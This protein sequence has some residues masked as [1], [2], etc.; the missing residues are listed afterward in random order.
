M[1]NIQ[2]KCEYS[3]SVERDNY[4]IINCKSCGYWHVYPIPSEEEL[5]TYYENKYYKSLINTEN[6]S[7]TDKKNDHDGFYT[8]Y[9]EDKLRH[10]NNIL[11]KEMPRTIIDIG[12][13]YGD[14]LSFMNKND[15]SVQGIEP[16]KEAYDFSKNEDLNI[17]C[18][19]F[20]EILDL[21][22]KKSSVVTLNNV[23]EHLREP[24]RVLLEI[25]EHLL[26]PDG[27]LSI[28]IPNDFSFFQNLQMKTTLKD[29]L[30]KQYYWVCPLDHL[31]YWS[32]ETIQ[33]FLIRL[34]FE[35]KYITST[36]PIDMFPLMGDDYVTNPEIGR[37]THLKEVRFE[38]ILQTTENWDF[39]DVFYYNLAKLGIGREILVYARP[40]G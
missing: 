23:L 22:F 12:A 19:H 15:W 28:A 24:E 17:R 36:F 1:I 25:K 27:I 20:E 37:N 29:N 8:I 16:S 7:M 32:H 4:T 31:N 6:R 9:Y 18:G 2:S 10:I 5:N 39:K 21:G 11:P 34:G 40:F 38:K 30:D 35:I 3:E 14:F 13:G 26:L 33:K